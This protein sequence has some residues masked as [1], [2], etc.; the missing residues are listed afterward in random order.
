MGERAVTAM[1][2]RSR[3]FTAIPF[4]AIP[5]HEL[6]KDVH[7]GHGVLRCGPSTCPCHRRDLRS[8]WRLSPRRIRSH[9]ESCHLWAATAADSRPVLSG[10]AIRSLRQAG[11]C[12]R[13][14]I[15]SSRSES[16]HWCVCHR[17]LHQ[18][19]DANGRAHAT[20]QRIS[21]IVVGSRR[22][23]NEPFPPLAMRKWINF[24]S[25]GEPIVPD[26]AFRQVEADR[27]QIGWWQR[28][29]HSGVLARRKCEWPQ[30]IEM[31]RC[32]P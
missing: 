19:L 17:S 4:H 11:H 16:G 21:K 28:D 2:A 14:D 31:K 1:A 3:R 15:P 24:F 27:E 32:R 18:L 6:K 25:V 26:S 29:D 13:S 10:G 8:G 9:G 20:G 12:E 23:F 7:M 5:F 30:S 22:A